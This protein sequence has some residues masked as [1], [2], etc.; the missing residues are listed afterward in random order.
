MIFFVCLH[1]ELNNNLLNKN[2]KLIKK[3]MLNTVVG[4]FYPVSFE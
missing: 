4:F 1:T 2:K 3:W